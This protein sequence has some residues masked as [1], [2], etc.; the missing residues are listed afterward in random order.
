MAVEAAGLAYKFEE[1]KYEAGRS[2]IYTFD[3]VRSRLSSARSE[4]AQ[5]KY[6]FLFRSRILA[7]YNGVNLL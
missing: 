3:Q 6:N 5:A 7:F 2:N 1:Q 4:A